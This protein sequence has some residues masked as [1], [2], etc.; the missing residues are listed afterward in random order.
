MLFFKPECDKLEREKKSCIFKKTL[1][2]CFQHHQLLEE[3]ELLR[4]F[5]GGWMDGRMDEAI[6][7]F[8]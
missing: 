8:Y 2:S 3:K 4:F 6:R 1:V 7:D 5:V